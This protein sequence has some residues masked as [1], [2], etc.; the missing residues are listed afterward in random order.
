MMF[1]NDVLTGNYSKTT[2]DDVIVRRFPP[3]SNQAF[4][5]LY[6]ETRNA[7]K[8]LARRHGSMNWSVAVLVPTRRMT[9]MISDWFRE[10]LSGRYPIRHH[11]VVDMEA[12]ILAAEVIALAL[13]RQQDNEEDVAEFIVL[14]CN[15]YRGKGGES[16]AMTHLRE[17]ERVDTAYNKAIARRR[18]GKEAVKNSLFL[19]MERT[20]LSRPR[21]LTGDPAQ[22]WV[23]MRKHFADGDCRRLKEVARDVRNVRLLRRG[24]QLRDDL[25]EAWRDSG[26][27]RD[28]LAILR[29]ALVRHHFAINRRPESGVVIMN[30][31]KAKG[32]QFDEVIIFEGWPRRQGR[33]VTN[34]DRIVPGNLWR[35]VDDSARQN[36]RVSISRAKQRTTIFT[37]ISDHCVILPSPR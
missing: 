24:T 35:N 11:A 17:A 34:Q 10:P 7:I 4:T 6:F 8:R 25:S 23:E 12:A 22:D 3:N 31:H 26:Y 21:Q 19:P 1:A 20:W 2:Y 33:V 29:Q 5:R 36:L 13:Q 27:Y 16:P 30:M 28:A 15:Y 18:G 32:K 37:P 9:R 14:V